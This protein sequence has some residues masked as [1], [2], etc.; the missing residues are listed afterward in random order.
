M[1]VCCA[2]L[3]TLEHEHATTHFCLG[4]STLQPTARTLS[5][6]NVLRQLKYIARCVRIIS[7]SGVCWSDYRNI[8]R[9]LPTQYGRT[10]LGARHGADLRAKDPVALSLAFRACVLRRSITRRIWHL[11]AALCDL[12]TVWPMQSG[13]NLAH[14]YAPSSQLGRV[15]RAC[16]QEYARIREPN[17]RSTHSRVFKFGTS[18]AR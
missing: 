3:E 4:H 18:V 1:C 12:A 2:N 11:M 5:D 8:K 9:K 13:A 15:H 14:V 10:G 17:T 6:F 16:V 7:I